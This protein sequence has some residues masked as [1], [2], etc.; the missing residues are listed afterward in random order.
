[1]TGPSRIQVLQVEDCPLVG[2]LVADLEACL[3]EVGVVE[4][5][6]SVVEVVVGDYPSPTLLVDGVD[7]ATGEPLAGQP[8]CR[9]DLPSRHQIR[10]VIAR[11]A[12]RPA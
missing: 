3:A 2:T 4:P 12:D 7:V 8:R 10:A 5:V 9:M 11:L 1:V 6:G